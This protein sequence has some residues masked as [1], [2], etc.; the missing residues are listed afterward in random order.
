M[1]WTLFFGD[2]IALG[3]QGIKDLVDVGET[4]FLWGPPEKEIQS[5]EA[6]L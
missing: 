1:I 6:P 4:E 3:I 2:Q 5:G